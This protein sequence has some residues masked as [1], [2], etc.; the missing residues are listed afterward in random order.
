[1]KQALR[2]SG[3]NVT[4]KHILDVS[5][6]ALFLLE[7]AKKCDRVFGVSPESISHTIRD[8]KADIMKIHQQLL[9]KSIT[10]ENTERKTPIFVDPTE[11]GINTI[12]KGDWLSKHL[13][14]NFE[15]NLQSDEGRGEIDMDYELFDT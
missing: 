4:D 7:A 14:S 8:S 6:C 3:A 5:M 15:D 2:S 9:E 12:T 10:Q 13:Q 1:M 11:S